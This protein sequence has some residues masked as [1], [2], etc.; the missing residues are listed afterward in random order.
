M[1]S[2]YQ[3][4]TDVARGG[5]NTVTT[6]QYS[7]LLQ[8]QDATKAP[9]AFRRD[10]KVFLHQ[11]KNQGDELILVGDFNEA[12][13]EDAEGMVSVARSLDL[14]ELMG[15]R[16]NYAAPATYSRG[17]KCL[18]YGFATA[19]VC[20]AL[21]SCGYE[22][23]GHRFLSDH[24]AYFFDFDIHSLFGTAIQPLSKFEP[25]LLHS[26]HP[27]QV[28]SYLRKMNSIMFLSC[29]AYERGDHLMHPGRRDAFAERLDSDVLAGS[30]SSERAIPHFQTP[31]WSKTLATVRLQVSTLQKMLSCLRHGKPPPHDLL[32]QFQQYCSEWPLLNNKATC[33][34]HLNEARQTVTTSHRQ[35]Q[36]C[37]AGCSVS[38]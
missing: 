1:V 22:S 16:H 11:C 12:M 13:G 25:R 21:T 17:R 6:Q 38:D 28:T 2:A 27:K 9:R 30:L 14:I 35:R 19:T 24:R 29:N 34:A 23:F 3:V 4:V 8:E 5:T 32:A 18:D 36:L 33:Q 31:E 26:T 20:A 10:L 15:A 37:P 7:L